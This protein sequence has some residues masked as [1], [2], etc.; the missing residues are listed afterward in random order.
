MVALFR[1]PI[2]LHHVSFLSQKLLL[3]AAS[4]LTLVGALSVGADEGDELKTLTT[5]AEVR[6]LTPMEAELE[7]PVRIEGVVTYFDAD[8]NLAFIQDETGGIYFAP[9][10][11]KKPD[12]KLEN[13]DVRDGMRV[14]IRGISGAGGYSPTVAGV[15]GQLIRVNRRGQAKMPE[16]IRLERGYLL[17]PALDSMWVEVDG[18]VEEETVIDD[19]RVLKMRTGTQNYLAVFSGNPDRVKLPKDLTGAEVRLQGVYGSVIDAS[20]RLTGLRLFIPDEKFLTVLDRGEMTA[21]DQPPVSV[22]DLMRFRPSSRS[23]A[24]VDGLVSAAFPDGRVYLEVDGEGLLVRQR[25]MAEVRPGDF[26]QAAGFPLLEEGQVVLEDALLRVERD[27][28][29]PEPKFV[30]L[31]RL[32]EDPALADELVEVDVLLRDR[33]TQG[34]QALFLLEEGGHQLL[35]Q[36][37]LARAETA[38][39]VALNS[40]VRI[41]GI[42][43]FQPAAEPDAD[44]AIVPRLLLRSSSDIMILREPPFWTVRRVIILASVMIAALAGGMI[45]VLVLNRKLE[46]QTLIIAEKVESERIGEERTRI[47]RELH[48]TLEQELAG[49]GMQLD[50]ASSRMR[51]QPERASQPLDLALQMLRRSQAEARRSIMNLRS[52]LLEQRNLADAIREMIATSQKPNRPKI[53]LKVE[54]A[55]R[56]LATRSEHNLLRICQESINN[57]NK[58]ARSASK[59][60]LFLKFTDDRVI[61]I[62]EDDGPGFEQKSPPKPAQPGRKS[63]GLLGMRERASKI[64]G[65]LHID[66]RPGEGTRITIDAVAL[67][68]GS[69][70]SDDLFS[71]HSTPPPS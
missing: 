55:P 69:G 20:G 6:A 29:P 52:G 70:Q 34:N 24:R 50:L 25:E 18:T 53:S 30:R 19:R 60:E 67:E 65:S 40:W 61:L 49:I 66:S 39:E 9:S 11:R 28:E 59:I 48:D 31:E 71:P 27:E 7:Y 42:S 1:E 57:V 21:F 44:G 63:F 3:V 62:I 2:N 54:G 10:G 43:D 46:Q 37:P 5:A 35:A 23:R 68:P 41:T 14:Q 4:G 38:P 13:L 56:K 64:G 26:V 16:P 47:A 45:W 17:S 32:V 15:D 58:H 36:L 22:L 8:K 12:A 33:F 51:T